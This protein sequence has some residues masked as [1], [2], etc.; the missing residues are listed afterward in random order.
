MN[1]T[2][3]INNNRKEQPDRTTIAC[4]TKVWI[5]RTQNTHLVTRLPRRTTTTGTFF[6]MMAIMRSLSLVLLATVINASFLRSNTKQEQRNLHGIKTIELFGLNASHCGCPEK[7]CQTVSF[8]KSINPD[9]LETDIQ[10]T[11]ADNCD[12][13]CLYDNTTTRTFVCEENVL[14]MPERC[15]LPC[16]KKDCEEVKMCLPFPTIHDVNLEILC[17]GKNDCPFGECRYNIDD[18]KLLCD[19]TNGLCGYD[20]VETAQ[21]IP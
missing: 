16:V 8:F 1:A 15:N 6:T 21:E 4:N 7:L 11:S 3:S 5:P 17:Q 12:L 13:A 14:N 19:N 18:H 2:S 10:C 20:C 9:I